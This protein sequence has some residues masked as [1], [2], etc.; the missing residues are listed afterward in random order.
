[1]LAACSATQQQVPRPATGVPVDP[2]SPTRGDITAI[3]TVEADA[4]ANPS[5]SVD[6]PNGGRVTYPP[7]PGPGQPFDTGVSVANIDGVP[8]SAAGYGVVLERLAPAATRVGAG[9]PVVALRYGG[10]GVTGVI[11][12]EQA[13][14]LYSG[15]TTARVQ[16]DGGPAAT[17][18]TPATPHNPAAAASDTPGVV[19]LCLLPDTAGLLAGMTGTMAFATGSAQDVIR[20]PLAAVA[21]TAGSGRVVVVTDTGTQT[22]D[23]ELGISDGINIEIRS[24]LAENERILPY[25]PNLRQTIR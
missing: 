1:M 9:A 2:I 6:A 19:V 21:G 8:L 10:F 12:V 7:K 24:G 13:Y 15:A 22:R 14:R 4:V 16:F 20:V 3:L 18:C 5:Y 25:G 17:E 23:V 11:P